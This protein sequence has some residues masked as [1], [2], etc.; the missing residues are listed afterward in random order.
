MKQTFAFFVGLLIFLAIIVSLN[1]LSATGRGSL[2]DVQAASIVSNL[3]E[4]TEVA[5]FPI[6][7]TIIC[8]PGRY[9]PGPCRHLLD[10]LQ[11]GAQRRF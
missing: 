9:G 6:V 7:T 1:G 3:D 10:G 11:L 4:F 8:Q 2:Q 5:N